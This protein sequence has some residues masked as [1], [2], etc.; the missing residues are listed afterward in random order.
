MTTQQQEQ[1]SY[2]RPNRRQETTNEKLARVFKT[3][4]EDMAKK[5]GLEATITMV[6]NRPS[7]AFNA[8]HVRTLPKM[9]GLLW[10]D[11]ATGYSN[12]SSGTD[13]NG[14]NPW[15]R[16]YGAI[17]GVA[18]VD[19][20]GG[21]GTMQASIP[22][23][24][25]ADRKDN[26]GQRNA[27]NAG[28]GSLCAKHGKLLGNGLE[29]NPASVNLYESKQRNPEGI[30]AFRFVVIEG[31]GFFGKDTKGHSYSCSLRE[32]PVV[33]PVAVEGE[34]EAEKPAPRSRTRRSSMTQDTPVTDGE[35]AD[36]GGE[37]VT[38]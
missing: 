21:Y 10:I 7:Y 18:H 9:P 8:T 3:I 22:A 16:Y 17:S 30:P 4:G 15:E 32:F 33:K 29:V 35:S 20:D 14:E 12:K 27:L 5:M 2:T 38:T 24:V 19:I 25:I 28:F 6:N 37:L 34:E 26:E 13:A 31:A 11:A 1:R 36:V 23:F